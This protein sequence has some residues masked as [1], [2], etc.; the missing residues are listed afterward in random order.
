MSGLHLRARSLG[1]GKSSLAASNHITTA[2]TCK[3][4]RPRKQS[5]SSDLSLQRQ[6]QVVTP[7]YADLDLREKQELFFLDGMKIRLMVDRS[8]TYFLWGWGTSP[9]WA[10]GY[11]D[12]AKCC[13]GKS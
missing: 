13:S 6:Q 12:R 2:A 8:Q 10:V 3:K 7:K 1:F 5:E 11:Y 9:H 4:S